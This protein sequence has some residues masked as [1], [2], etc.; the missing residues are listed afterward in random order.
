MNLSDLE[1]KFWLKGS[2]S[3]YGNAC[4]VRL[5]AIWPIYALIWCLILLNEFRLELIERR[6]QSGA[7]EDTK[8]E[9]FQLM[10]LEKAQILLDKIESNDFETF[11]NVVYE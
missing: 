1:V 9:N 5:R 11:L 4:F 3:I 8:L 10:Q 7:F 2:L 6:L